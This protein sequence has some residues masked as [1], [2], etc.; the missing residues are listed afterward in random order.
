MEAPLLR[1]GCLVALR[2]RALLGKSN[3]ED[4]K[5]TW[6]HVA[7]SVNAPTGNVKSLPARNDKVKWTEYSLKWIANHKQLSH[8][9]K[10]TFFFF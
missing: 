4:S 8:I 2:L 5:H 6:A 9:C 7:A 10:V 1:V 3:P